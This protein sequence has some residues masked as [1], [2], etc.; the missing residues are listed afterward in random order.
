MK[1]IL[2]FLTQ[3]KHGQQTQKWLVVVP[4]IKGMDLYFNTRKEAR[5]YKTI[6]RQSCREL[7]ARIVRHDFDGDYMVGEEVVS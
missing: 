7:E 3:K 2:D 5:E 6:L 1:T 4:G